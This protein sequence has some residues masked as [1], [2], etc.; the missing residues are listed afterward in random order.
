M[1]RNY[2]FRR[3][4]SSVHALIGI[5]ISIR[6]I[7]DNSLE[8]HSSP[9]TASVKSAACSQTCPAGP[10]GPPGI[11]GAKG[12]SGRDGQM[13]P[14][15]DP[16][17][18]GTKGERGDK[19]DCK[20]K[21]NVGW[22]YLD[23]FYKEAKLKKYTYFFEKVPST[24]KNIIVIESPSGKKH[25]ESLFLCASICGRMLLPVSEKENDE[26]FSMLGTNG[27]T[28]FHAFIRISDAGKEG[29]W[30]DV[31]HKAFVNYT[32]WSSGKPSSSQSSYDYASLNSNG[33]WYAHSESDT[34]R[35]IICELS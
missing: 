35:T 12:D 33:K 15:G 25:S 4:P 23:K 3:F 26:V 28:S 13:G 22:C 30:R 14:K 32:N 16:G 19:G 21:Q 6:A 2:E 24:S 27:V 9:I 5:I 20:V 34:R 1:D 7:V 18:S 10:A 17:I 31:E 11:D 8:I 29:V